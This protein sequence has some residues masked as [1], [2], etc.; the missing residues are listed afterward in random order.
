MSSSTA[1][2]PATREPFAHFLVAGALLF[3]LHRLV[4]EPEPATSFDV[5]PALRES[6]RREAER[7]QGRAPSERELDTLLE[8]HVDDQLRYR[9][10][11]AL[12]LDRADPVIIRRVIQKLDFL[13]EDAATLTPPQPEEIARYYREHAA[14]LARAERIT[15]EHVFFSHERRGEAVEPEADQAL[16]LLQSVPRGAPRPRD[17]G[18]PFITGHDLTR[19]TSATVRARLGQD[20]ADTV[21][22]AELGS[23]VGPVSSPW[24]VH[25]VRVSARA[26]SSVPPLDEVRAD[27]VRLLD[28]DRRAAAKRALLVKLRARH[29]L[30]P[31]S[32]ASNAAALALSQAER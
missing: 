14:E 32:E 22:D 26:G 12:G 19:V 25:L 15:L 20:V 18:D 10:G 1:K 30:P 5:E 29:G 11:L 2:L 23:W 27:V 28:R 17:L 16:A 7:R 3:G 31:P 8:R 9:E 21:T 13:A 4:A 6:L 24:G